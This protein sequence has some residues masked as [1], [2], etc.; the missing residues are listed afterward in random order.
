MAIAVIAALCGI[1]N[2][3]GIATFARVKLEWLRTLLPL[4]NGA[5]SHDTFSRVFA[6]IKPEQFQSCFTAWMS[7]VAELSNGE[8]VAL[9]GK[10][11]RR[12]FDNAAGKAAIH[13]VSA[14]A[15]HNG[16]SLGQ[17]KVDD[18]SNEITAIP[19]LLETLCL[20]GCIVTID[21]MGC[22]REIAEK[23]IVAEA[24]YTLALKANQPKLFEDV[25]A[26]FQGGG[27][28]QMHK[29]SNKAHGREEIRRYFVISDIDELNSK[30]GWPGLKSV[31][32]V[33]STTVINGQATYD[34]R[35]Y[36]MSYSADPAKFAHAVRSHWSVEAMHWILDVSSNDDNSRVR[37]GNGAENL[38]TVRRIA[39]NML[40][41]VPGKVS[42][43]QKNIMCS[44]DPAYLLKVLIS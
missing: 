3:E 43:P 6:R 33:K 18:K 17:V 25:Q 13:M 44:H 19:E 15:T 22:Q 20:K 31:G 29:T 34:E 32:L 40:K 35:F 42:I 41:R 4:P 16:V 14:W 7:E 38:S 24:D 21:A 26:L 37:K 8:V 27:S 11:L 1:D 36:L 5:P 12:S 10:T 23:I 39:I 28:V 9:D 30:H 2:F